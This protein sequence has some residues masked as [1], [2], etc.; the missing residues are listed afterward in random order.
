MASQHVPEVIPFKSPRHRTGYNLTE[1]LET[2][3]EFVALLAL[4]KGEDQLPAY[5][6]MRCAKSRGGAKPKPA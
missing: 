4:V 1:Y 6:R 3:L 2:N 5:I